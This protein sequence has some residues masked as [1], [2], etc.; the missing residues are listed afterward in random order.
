MAKGIR[1]NWNKEKESGDLGWSQA[2]IDRIGRRLDA[3]DASR[4]FGGPVRAGNPY[5]VGER[6]PEVF[7]PDR[8]GTILPGVPGG[9]DIVLHITNVMDGL[10]VAEV[11]ERHRAQAQRRVG[12]PSFA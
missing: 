6:R 9:G 4:Q 10:T 8:N 3:Y 2:E 11:V 12:L 5:L 1:A 7:I